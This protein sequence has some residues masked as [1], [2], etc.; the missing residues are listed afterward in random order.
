[1]FGKIKYRLTL[2]K[3]FLPFASGVQRFFVL[4]LALSIVSMALGFANPQFY[5]LFIDEVIIAKHFS[6]M[7][8]V[9]GGYFGV[10]LTT[11]AISYLRNHS[12]NT[13]VNT[14]LYRAKYEIFNG[15][16]AL[17]FSVYEKTS[18]GDMKMRLEDDTAQIN[19]FAGTQSIDYLIA[20]VTLIVSA[21]WLITID[22]RLAA[23][24][25]VA[26]P[27][28]F[29]LDHII[30]KRERVLNNVNR[31]NDQKMTAWLHT[32]V[33]G[34]REVKA[35]NLATQQKR[36]FIY[37]RRLFA[38]FFA[39]WINYWTLRV[40]VIPKVKEEFFMRFGLYF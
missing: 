40:L 3:A 4:N 33:Q 15:L 19:N 26:I 24:S 31:E 10:F 7:P 39:K 37:Y 12:T 2:L 21:V 23:F 11:T 35:L 36:Q 20:Y 17:P 1:M 27:L 30:S 13:L 14:V 9:I 8:M 16:F 32:S 29:W 5:R 28:T 6:A 25:I 38:L 18:I 34:W 22:W